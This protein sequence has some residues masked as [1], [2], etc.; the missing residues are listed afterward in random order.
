MRFFNFQLWAMYQDEVR[1]YGQAI[2]SITDHQFTLIE[3]TLVR[4]FII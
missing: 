3:K 4:Y 2:K 1:G